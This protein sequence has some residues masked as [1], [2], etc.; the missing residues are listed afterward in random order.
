[1]FIFKVNAPLFYCDLLYFFQ[2]DAPPN[3]DEYSKA[4]VLVPSSSIFRL[5]NNF[6]TLWNAYF[7]YK[8]RNFVINHKIIDVNYKEEFITLRDIDLDILL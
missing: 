6:Y 3:N 5:Q 8:Y 2:S 4:T 1:M 7:F